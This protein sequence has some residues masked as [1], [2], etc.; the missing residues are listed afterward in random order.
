VI[1]DC[2]KKSY[3]KDYCDILQYGTGRTRRY[4]SGTLEKIK[5]R[6]KREEGRGTRRGEGEGME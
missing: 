2:V 5:G 4:K 6:G 1:F 3:G